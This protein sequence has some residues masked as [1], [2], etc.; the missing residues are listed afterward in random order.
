MANNISVKDS[1]ATNVVVKTTDNAAVHTP[2]HNVDAL[3]GTV[4][5]DITAIKTAVEVID[6][7]ISG[8][9]MQVDVVTLPG[10]SVANLGT[11]AGA[12][13]GTEMQVDVLTLPNVTI[14]A[15]IA[16]GTNAIGTVGITEKTILSATGTAA[17]SG[18]NELIAAGGGGVVIVIVAAWIQNE[19]ASTTTMILKDGSTAFARFVAGQREMLAPVLGV[20]REFKLTANTALNLNLS[21]ANS[22]GYTIF[23]YTES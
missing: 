11:I 21:A 13:A 18:D 23:Y 15:A 2:H 8:S 6:N 16:A 3:P 10:S 1:G 7:A 5:T 22:A 4:E 19:S 9:E 14:G 20:G 12:V 17:I